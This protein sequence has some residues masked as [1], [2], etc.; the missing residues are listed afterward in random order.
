VFLRQ[1]GNVLENNKKI[2]EDHPQR[3]CNNQRNFI[4][5][6]PKMTFNSNSVNPSIHPTT[7]IGPFAVIIGDVAI[8]ENVF[9]APHAS[10]R[11]DEGSPF[12]IGANSNIQDGVILHGLKDQSVEVN[13]KNYSIYIGHGVS[14]AHGS[15]I[16][17]PSYIGHGVFVGFQ[18]IVFKAVIGDGAF[19]SPKALITNGV[20]I[21]P[22]R[23]VPLGAVID[24][25]AQADNLGFKSTAQEQLVDR[26]QGVNLEFSRAYSWVVPPKN[27]NE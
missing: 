21:G 1:G 23:F 7:F 9:I 4:G 26:V 17:G 19:V 15:I 24:E 20:V 10:I 2:E 18:A 27:P 14:C 8:G 6:N 12:F 11:A 16:H 25:Q 13:G 3:R 5:P 22:N